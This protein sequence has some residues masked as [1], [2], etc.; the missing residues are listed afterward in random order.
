MMELPVIG[1]YHAGIPEL[2]THEKSGLLVPERDALALRDAIAKLIRNSSLCKRL[3]MTACKQMLR[4]DIN[5]INDQ[6]HSIL[7]RLC[8]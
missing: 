1:T 6:L 5:N 7:E 2:I 4:Y 8:E 3:G